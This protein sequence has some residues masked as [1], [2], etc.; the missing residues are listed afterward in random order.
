MIQEKR[1]KFYRLY[2]K[3]ARPFRVQVEL[4]RRCNLNCAHCALGGDTIIEGEMVA[5]DYERLIPEMKAAGVFNIYLTGGEFLTHPEIDSI[6]DMLLNADFWISLQ[7]NGT[8]MDEKRVEMIARKAE[9]VR[10]V[11]LSL[12]GATA[13]VHES[14]TR[15]EGSFER[16]VRALDLL[17]DAGLKVELLTLLMSLN[18]SERESIKRFCEE[19]GVKH[20]FNSVLVP[21]KNDSMEMLKYRLT[22]RQLRALPRPWETFNQNFMEADPEDYAPDRTIEAWCSMA[23]STGYLD[24]QG[25]LLPCSVL[26]IPS[27][28]VRETPFG[29]L[30]AESPVFKHIRELK[31]GDFECAGCGHFPTCMPCPGLAYIEHGDMFAAPREICRIVKLFLEKKEGS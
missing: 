11:A 13:A 30:W 8:L 26:A 4:T 24:S 20:Q 18:W 15:V 25:N 6:L 10:S 17:R 16:T 22:E 29:Q 7:T 28:N 21:G 5:E 1:G 3:A 19:K 14:V 27:G 23:R 9:K 2:E 31:I 12:Y